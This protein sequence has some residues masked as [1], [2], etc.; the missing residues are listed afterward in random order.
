MPDVGLRWGGG[1]LVVLLQVQFVELLQ[2]VRD[3]GYVLGVVEQARSSEKPAPLDA[4]PELGLDAAGWRRFAD[5]VERADS[6]ASP[7]SMAYRASR[8]GWARQTWL[9]FVAQP[10]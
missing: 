4:E 9:S 2:Q 6:S 7:A 8:I 1:R 3:V 5:G 10:G